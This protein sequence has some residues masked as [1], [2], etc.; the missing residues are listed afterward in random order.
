[1]ITKIRIERFKSIASAEL[2][3]GKINVLVGANNSGKSSILQAIQFATSVAQTSMLYT[4]TPAIFKKEKWSTT[5][6]P[7]QLIYSPVKDPYTLGH[8]GNL[9]ENERSKGID[10]GIS[11]SFTDDLD[12]TVTGKISKGKNKN[13]SVEF[14][15]SSFGM[16]LTAMDKPFCMYVPGLA[17]ITFEEEIRA[18]GIVRKIAA[19]GDSNTVFRNVLYRLNQEPMKWEKF[20]TNLKKIF[21]EIDISVNANPEADGYIDV[22]FTLNGGTSYLPIDLA[23]T[24]V[25]QAIQITAY[26]SYFQPT[27]LLLDEPDSHLHPTNQRLLA[28]LLMALIRDNETTIIISTHS[29]HLMSALHN[30]AKFFLVRN[31]SV[32][33]EKYDYFSWLVELGALDEY[34]RIRGGELKYIVLTE[35]GTRDGKEYLTNIL[36][37]SGFSEDEFKIFSY[38]GVSSVNS[39]KLFASFLADLNPNLTVIIYR[40]RDGLYDEEIDKIKKDVERTEEDVQGHVR[41][42]VANYNDIEMYYCNAEHLVEVCASKGL[43]L[44]ESEADEIIEKAMSA[45][46]DDSQKKF[47]GHR[48]P[49]AKRKD[50]GSWVVEATKRYNANK[51]VFAYG[52]KV[53]GQVSSLLQSKYKQNVSIYKMTKYIADSQF[54]L[55]HSESKPLDTTE[56]GKD[57]SILV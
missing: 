17:G 5:V 2:N 32:S 8:G 44:S 36:I 43:S 12:N 47:F 29:R 4:K 11:I 50:D 52:K 26:V 15:S 19:K 37:A 6:A 42:V 21:P 25:L 49:L 31:G 3:L 20:M 46:E 39:A 23:G 38:Q 7:T 35:D 57:V 27:L 34:D 22:K 30:D 18:I 9:P 45:V 48:Q 53:A 24:G 1:M 55:I 40:D 16:Q 14:N 41:F 51:R 10:R 56:K 54:A 33:N 13:I 28:E